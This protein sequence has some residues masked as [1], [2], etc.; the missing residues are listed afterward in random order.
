MVNELRFQHIVEITRLDSCI[1]TARDSRN[2]THIY[3]MVNHRGP[4]FKRNG[5]TGGWDHVEESIKYALRSLL[6]RA[7]DSVARYTADFVS[8]N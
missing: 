6:E 1:A 7:G 5:L 2:R 3:L 4:V 8:L